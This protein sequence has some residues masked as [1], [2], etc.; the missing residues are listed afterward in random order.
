MIKLWDGWAIDT[1]PYQFILG[2]PVTAQRKDGRTVTETQNATYHK[3]L[4]QALQ[5]F[6][7]MKV[8]ECVGETDQTLCR[9]VADV[10]RIEERIRSLMAEPDFKE[11]TP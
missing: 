3:T 6:Y 4:G 9:A 2:Q 8:R 7:R 10:C 1:D 11:A 5:A